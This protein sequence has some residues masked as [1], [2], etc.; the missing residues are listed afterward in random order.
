MILAVRFQRVDEA[1]ELPQK[2]EVSGFKGLK[3][4]SISQPS[5][6]AH[7]SSPIGLD[8]MAEPL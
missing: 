1:L 2:V 6:P 7:F 8:F 5:S 3:T 4:L